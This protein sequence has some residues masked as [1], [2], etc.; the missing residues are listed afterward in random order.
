MPTHATKGWLPSFSTTATRKDTVSH[1]EGRT[2]GA[3]LDSCVWHPSE[4]G[5]QVMHDLISANQMGDERR[6]GQ[7]FCIPARQPHH[8]RLT[9]NAAADR[10]GV[11]LSVP[12]V[13]VVGSERQV[14]VSDGS[15][16]VAM[17]EQLAKLV[18]RHVHCVIRDA[19]CWPPSSRPPCCCCHPEPHPSRVAA[20][21]R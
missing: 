12:L 5:V 4:Q 21:A 19:V 3:P 18:T 6:H 13:E 8:S 14:R 10:G 20:S 16:Y 11:F 1:T 17:L 7:I 2:G 9:A 15:E